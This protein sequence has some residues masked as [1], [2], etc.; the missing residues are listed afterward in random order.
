M[1]P[2]RVACLLFL[3]FPSRSA[4]L[5]LVTACAVRTGCAGPRLSFLPRFALLC[6]CLLA[7]LCWA[8]ALRPGSCP[9]G[10]GAPVPPCKQTLL[11]EL[12]RMVLPYAINHQLTA[13][14]EGG[15]HSCLDICIAWNT[16]FNFQDCWQIHGKTLRV[17]K[18]SA[19]VALQ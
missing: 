6:T 15:G 3:A 11:R 5:A 13:N 19:E 14:I 10:G 1:H 7:A 17:S 18:P 2:P 8:L 12:V 16:A 9:H 4:P